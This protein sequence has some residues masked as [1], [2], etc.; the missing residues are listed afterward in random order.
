MKKGR[1]IHSFKPGQKITRGEMA[2]ITRLEYNEN[3]GIETER[4]FRQDGSFIGDELIYLGIRNN[5]IY[6]QPGDDCILS[7]IISIPLRDYEQGWIEYE[8][9]QILIDRLEAS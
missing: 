7:A 6:L 1:S 8:S 9:P 4:L 2:T 3:L 5:C